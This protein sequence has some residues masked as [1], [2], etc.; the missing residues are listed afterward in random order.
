MLLFG[1]DIAYNF[2]NHQRLIALHNDLLFQI[3]FFLLLLPF[4]P[5]CR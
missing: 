3:G 5:S 4:E 2:A 1:E